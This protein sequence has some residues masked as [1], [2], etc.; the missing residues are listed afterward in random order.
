V[1]KLKWQFYF[2]IEFNY[3]CNLSDIEPALGRRTQQMEAPVGS[4]VGTF[5]QR[6]VQ[7]GIA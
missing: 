5:L 7:G 1:L 6:P 4:D 2:G 3:C